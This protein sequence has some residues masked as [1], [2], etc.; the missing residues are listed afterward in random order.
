MSY[1]TKW[2][3]RR[4]RAAVMVAAVPWS[5]VAVSLVVVLLVAFTIYSLVTQGKRG[6]GWVIGGF[7]IMLA[8][9]VFTAF[10]R[11]SRRRRRV[12]WFGGSSS[13]FDDVSRGGGA[14]GSW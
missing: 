9:A 14:T 6:W 13:A 1:R 7:F 2:S 11:L 5:T 12:G 3:S 8:L 4:S 10:G